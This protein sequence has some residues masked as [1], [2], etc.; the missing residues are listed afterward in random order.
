MLYFPEYLSRNENAPQDLLKKMWYNPTV[1]ILCCEC[2]EKCEKNPE[3]IKDRLVELDSKTYSDMLAISLKLQEQDSAIKYSELIDI[4]QHNLASQLFFVDYYHDVNI[5]YRYIISEEKPKISE[6]LS[7]HES[8]LSNTTEN[9]YSLRI[10]GMQ[11]YYVH[12]DKIVEV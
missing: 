9:I 12:F 4:Y 2:F 11:I 6:Y 8:N 7:T 1:Q 3:L 5:K 10:N